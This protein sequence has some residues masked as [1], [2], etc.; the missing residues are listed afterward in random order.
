[1]D[2]ERLV[3]AHRRQKSKIENRNLSEELASDRSRIVY[4]PPFRRLTKKAQV[5]SLEINPAVR[6]RIT[7]SLEVADVGRLIAYAITD[8]LINRKTI[9]SNLQLPIIYAVENACLLH[10]IGNPPFGHFGETAIQTWFKKN[11]KYC[12]RKSRGHHISSDLSALMGDFL[13]FDGNPQGVRIVLRLQN[14]RDKYSLN[15]TS[16]TLL[17]L[18]KYVRSPSEPEDDGLGKKPGYFN[19]ERK[20][21]EEMKDELGLPSNSRHPLAYIMEAAD[22]IAYCISD[23]EDG[24]E[25]GIITASE[26]FDELDEAWNENGQQGK[27]FPI[28]TRPPR[29]DVP[30][31]N[32]QFFY[33]KTSYTREAIKRAK[34]LYLANESGLFNGEITSLFSDSTEE[35]RALKCLKTVARKKLFRSS[36]AEN[37]ELAGYKV[38]FGLL[39]SFKP[40]LLL[41]QARFA[42]LLES[43]MNPSSV[44]RQNLD[45]EW[46][47]FNKLAPKHIDAYKEQ[48]KDYDEWFS[49]CHLITDFISG[50][51]DGYALELFQL[52]NGIRLD[53][54]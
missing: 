19:S 35:G 6:N 48:I 31:P 7:H 29:E 22:D 27:V 30:D 28:G 43:R 45:Y 41:P 33:F 36:E 24:I 40:L 26:F 44:M 9:N 52:L 3:T 11:W 42:L 51:T 47:L 21:I 2:Y 17:S 20:L 8:E 5:F 14:V 18:V 12:F 37:P 32:M 25:K 46:R 54:I 38:I 1:M 15:L 39:D 13:Q 16:T 10:D 53:V 4:S 49:R 23:I 50:M 34:N